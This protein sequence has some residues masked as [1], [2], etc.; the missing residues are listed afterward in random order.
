LAGINKV[1]QGGLANLGLGALESLTPDELA[2]F[3]SAGDY[4]GRN[5]GD[6]LEFYKRSRPGQGSAMAA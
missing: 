2:S 5:T 1:Y 3:K 4:L 6:E